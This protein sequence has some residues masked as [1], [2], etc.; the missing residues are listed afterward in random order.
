MLK[1][2]NLL[3]QLSLEE[4]V[5]LITSNERIKNQQIEN[6]EFPTIGFINSLK[7]I[8]DSHITPSFNSLGSVYDTK[9]IEEYGYEIGK[10]LRSIKFDK[11]VNIPI[12]PISDNNTEA[13]SSS[14]L[15]SARLG[16]HLA[17]GIEN[18]G[19]LAAYSKL[20]GLK[21]I[22]LDSYFNDDLYSFKVAFSDYKPFSCLISSSDALDTVSGDYGYNGLKV[23]LA[24][25]D[26]DFKNS[27]NHK[28]TLSINENNNNVE[29]I[30]E[31]VEN[32][33]KLKRQLAKDEIT[34]DVLTSA[35]NSGEAIN[36]YSI[37]EML[38]ELLDK[39]AKFE[40]IKN[41][42]VEFNLDKLN[43]IEYRIA[44]GSVVLLKNDNN[45][46]PFKRENTVSFIGDQL[47]HPKFN[48][49]R[50][51][52]TNIL[53]IIDS[54]HLETRGIG[55]GYIKGHP[56]SEEVFEKA[57]NLIEGTEYSFVFLDTENNEIPEEEL[58]FLNRIAPYKEKTKIIPVLY[59]NSFVDITPLLQFD[60][61][62][63]NMGDSQSMIHATFDVITGKYNPTGR[64]PFAIKSDPFD[65]FFKSNNNLIYPLG[66]GLNYSKFNYTSITIDNGGIIL[67]VTN[68]SNLPGTDKLFFTS[69]YLSGEKENNIIRD[70]ITLDLEPH[71]S[72]IV[73]FKFNFNSFSVY[74][75]DKDETVIREGEY[76]V[77]LLT[78]FNNVLSEK[79]LSLK[80]L[81]SKEVTAVEL[82]R[83]YDNL[84]DS[85]KDFVSDVK[86][87]RMVPLKYKVLGL[88]LITAYLIAM[89]LVWFFFNDNQ[90][91]KIAILAVIGVIV[92]FDII[93]LIVIYKR[94]KQIDDPK[95]DDLKDV[96]NSMKTF[97]TISHQTYKEPIPDIEE[98][99]P[100]EEIVE[101]EIV[102]EA[103]P[104]KEVIKYVYDEFG[105]VI[106]DN[107]EY[108]DDSSFEDIINDFVQFA[109]N[110]N[111][112]IEIQE[113]RELFASL[114][115]SN[116]ILV[117]NKTD[118]LNVRLLDVLNKYLGNTNDIFVD[119]NEVINPTE[120]YWN[121]NENGEFVVSDFTNNLIR[122]SH[123][124]KRL[125]IFVF[126]NC[127]LSQLKTSLHAFLEFAKAP[128]ITKT[129]DIG[130]G[131]TITIPENTR[132]I[133]LVD[134]PN[135]LE[136]I[137]KE[138]SDLTT[139][140]E[141]L[142]RVNEITSE[143]VNVK[144]NSYRYLE[145]LLRNTKEVSYL[146]EE[147]WKKIDDFTEDQ[148]FT[149]FYIDSRTLNVC[150]KIIAVMLSTTN[151]PNDA[152]NAIFKLRII[153]M[154]KRTI[155]YKEN[156]GDRNI[157]ELIEKIFEDRLDN[158]TKYLKKPE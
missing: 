55:H 27:I 86:P 44:Q 102:E 79:V 76:K 145:F 105:E 150:E 148:M 29:L 144:Y 119:V 68:N 111:L 31:A 62:V 155:A 82:D 58:E 121:L 133:A 152:L 85:L 153:P 98:E 66:Y 123:L 138:I 120:I 52:E 96:I 3:N 33:E 51:V 134:D 12:N 140:I 11:I 90:Y 46:L 40:T 157:I 126:R 109:L 151:D 97:D 75:P 117:N 83:A 37:D 24:K 42:N 67:A 10:Y 28:A 104:E 103:E 129:I 34:N 128:K 137:D 49:D 143:K 14:R 19:H 122:A 39:L 8:I 78:D 80:A 106:E 81:S 108:T 74:L 91:A 1:Y 107:L 99:E 50:D 4:K 23:V 41:E 147:L 154:L 21:G 9:L 88:L 57:V 65:K 93:V 101:E 7:D 18:G 17:R 118:E 110:N 139:Y 70:F 100:E 71:E 115:S 131:H 43:E 16:S 156:H 112:I 56:F 94:S 38:D 124:P 64:L 127:K 30:L 116:F 25:N 135:F 47:F 158:S 84:D 77:Q 60:A 15:V 5:K 92:I 142:T 26:D 125:N 36:P 45:I 141:L 132:F 149:D 61:V 22:N 59:T 89:L 6:Y 69:E 72:K 113:A 146:N 53:N 130:D 35:V 73:E 114:M 95:V 13:F 136:G 2:Q 20:P 32:Y 54:Y 87:K 63:L 48:T